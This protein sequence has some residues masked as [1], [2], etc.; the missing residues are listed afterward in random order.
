M[1]CLLILDIEV[2]VEATRDDPNNRHSEANHVE[3]VD[4]GED[5]LEEAQGEAHE[6]NRDVAIAGEAALCHL[7]TFVAGVVSR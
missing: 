6:R 3:I 5:E 2:Q 7:L 1:A 4:G